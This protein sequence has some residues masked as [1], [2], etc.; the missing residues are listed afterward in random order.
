MFHVKHRETS[1]PAGSMITVSTVIPAYNAAP[2]IARAIDSVLAQDYANKEII[3][4]NDGSRDSTRSILDTYGTKIVVIDQPNRGAATARN[5][6]VAEAQ[7]EYLAFLDADDEWMPEKLT[8][9]CTA[10]GDNLE[11]VLAFSDYTRVDSRGEIIDEIRFSAAP[12]MQE[13]LSRIPA[14]IPSVILMRR[15]A[16]EKCGGFSKGFTWKFFEDSLMCVMVRELGEFVHVREPLVR[17]LFHPGELDD[18]YFLNGRLFVQLLRL[19]YGRQ[20]R[21]IIRDSYKN[22]ASVAFE[23][24]GRHWNEG[25]LAASAA[26]LCEAARFSPL[27]SS[28]RLLRRLIGHCRSATLRRARS[29]V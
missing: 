20:A 12:T 10:I 11:A 27:R 26:R 9:L 21:N 22:M 4:V 7:G 5:R 13:M 28:G 16:F 25:N 1:K 8:R 3:V 14:I 17:H 15:A 23:D 19:R 6:G 2:T 29:P 18:R 24:A